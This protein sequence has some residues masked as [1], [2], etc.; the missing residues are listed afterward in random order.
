MISKLLSYLI[1]VPYKRITSNV[2]SQLEVTWNNG[3]LVLDTPNTNYSYGNL[4]KILKKGLQYIGFK[5]IKNMDSVLILGLGAGS[6]LHTLRTEIDYQN[7]I[8]SVELDPAVLYTAKKYF[9]IDRFKNHEIIEGDAFEYVLKNHNKKFDLIVLDLFQDVTMPSF[10]FEKYFVNN[11]KS[12]LSING[13]ILFNT[14]CL[15]NEHLE[16]NQEYLKLYDPNIFSL[17]QLP[18]LQNHNEIITIKRIK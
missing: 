5:K 4:E 3:K 14:I 18:K 12:M 10:L 6:I 17:R 13:F 7:H 1:P 11:L 15:T 9:D 16:R 2:N 8:V